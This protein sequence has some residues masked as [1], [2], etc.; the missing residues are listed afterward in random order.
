MLKRHYTVFTFLQAL[1]TD[2]STVVT[3]SENFGAWLSATKNLRRLINKAGKSENMATLR[4]DLVHFDV[5]L[6]GG[7]VPHLMA[8]ELL[9]NMATRKHHVADFNHA[10]T[11]L[12]TT[13]LR[14]CMVTGLPN[15]RTRLA[16]CK[17]MVHE[18]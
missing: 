13:E 9:F 3:T 6:N 7:Q 16:A 1:P 8:H 5:A 10:K 18:R 11:T 4:N 14:T 15:P 17:A 2:T 12:F